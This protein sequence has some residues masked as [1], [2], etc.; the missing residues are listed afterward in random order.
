[1]PSIL[2]FKMWTNRCPFSPFMTLPS[3]FLTLLSLNTSRHTV[4]S[5]IT[6]GVNI[7]WLQIFTTASVTIGSGS[8]NRSPASSVLVNF[9][10]LLNIILK[11]LR[12]V[13]VIVPVILVTCVLIV[14]PA[15]LSDSLNRFQTFLFSC[16]CKIDAFCSF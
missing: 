3:S 8:Q 10:S 11:S 5:Y 16:Y 9:K 15:L 13:S 12:V 6:V 2:L 4:K 7:S 14:C 1:M